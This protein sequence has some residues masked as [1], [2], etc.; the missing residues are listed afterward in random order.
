ML[1]TTC[2]KSIL[3]LTVKFPTLI[4][5]SNVVS[6]SLSVGTLGGSVDIRCNIVTLT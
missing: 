6:V 3:I 2:N 5:V 4:N 1:F